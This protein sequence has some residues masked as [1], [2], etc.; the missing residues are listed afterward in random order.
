MFATAE[1]TSSTITSIQRKTEGARF[2]RK[3]ADE[4]FFGTKEGA[5]FFNAT[6]Q[7]KLS[8]SSPED[9]QEKEADA[10]AEQVMA[11]PE[12]AG[13]MLTEKKEEEKLQAREE[14]TASFGGGAVINDIQYKADVG[15][16][17]HQNLFHK[18]HRSQGETGDEGLETAACEC[19]GQTVNRKHILVQTSD[20]IQRT[21]R[22]PP[23][24]SVSFAQ[25]LA[26]SRGGGSALPDNTKQFMESRFNADFSGVRIHTGSTA[27]NLSSG[28]QAQAFTHGNDIYFNSN[29]YS[30]Q[31]SSGSLLL[32]HELTHTIQQGASTTNAHPQPNHSTAGSV[33]PKT[34][35]N[36][37]SFSLN[38][39]PDSNFSASR[40]KEH[41]EATPPVP[42]N[43]IQPKAEMSSWSID[44]G[45]KLSGQ[46]AVSNAFPTAT[47][48]RAANNSEDHIQA[49]EE[50]KKEEEPVVSLM[51]LAV[52]KKAAYPLHRAIEYN[53]CSA[54]TA[55]SNQSS[56]AGFA[57]VDN[58]LNAVDRSA[59]NNLSVVHDRGPPRIASTD[60][61]IHRSVLDDALSSVS[62]T[63]VLGCVDLLDLDA[64][65]ACVLDK[66]QEV[67]LHIPGF[68][69]LRVVLGYDPI[70]GDDIDRSG[71]NFIEAAFDIM[72][73][74]MLLHQKL[75]EQQQLDAAAAWIDV[76]MVKV[77]ELV[78]GLFGQINS[79]WDSLG[80]TDL[81]SPMDVL[82]DGTNI[83]LGFIGDIVDFAVE[84][85]TQL[86]EMVK[87]YLLEKIVDFI[88]EHTT[89][90]PLLCLVLGRDP[91]RDVEVDRN[92]TNILNALL[93]LGG[94]QGLMQKEQMQK[95]GT[96]QKVVDY[97]DQGIVVF[98]GAYEQILAGF[99]N[100]WDYVSIESLMDPGETFR[101]IFNQFAEPVLRVFLFVADVAAAILDYIKEV[102]MQRL[103]DWA[104][105]VRGYHVLTL[106]IGED[107]FTHEAVPFNVENVIHAF[108][109]LM[110][111]GEEQFQQM[112]QTGAIKRAATQV[113]AAV[114][115]LEMTPLAIIQLYIDLW[116]SFTLSD[117]VD[118]VSAYMRIL[119]TFAAPIF[120][121]IAFIAEIVRIVIYV[122][123]QI[124][125]FPFD[126]IDNIITR[127]MKAFAQ[128][129]ADP[130][131]FLK[132]ILKAIK[133]GFVQ[134]FEN[135]AT[136][137]LNGVT[138]WLLSELKDANVTAP[139]DFTL[140]GIISWVLELLGISMEKIWEKLAAHPRVGP[141]RVAQIKKSIAKLEG[142]WTFIRDVQ[143][144]GMAAIW[145]KIQEQLS[146]LWTVVLEAIT[147]WVMEKIIIQVTLYLLGLLDPTFIMS[148]V[149]S[150][151]IIYR[152]IRSFIRYAAQM[153]NV[154]NSFV[155]GI[156]DIAAGNIATAANYLEDSMGKAMPVVIGFL[157]DQAG[158]GGAGRKV[159]EMIESVREMVDKALTWLVNK[160]VD[161]GLALLDKAVALGQAA[162]G[163]VLDW[164]KKTKPV[165][166]K[167]GK[168]HTIYLEGSG[169][170][171]QLMM[172]STPGSYRNF[173]E[174]T[175]NKNGITAPL[176]G[177]PEEKA[178][179]KADE[180]D[181]RLKGYGKIEQEYRAIWG[182]Q[183]AVMIDDLALLTMQL[184]I[185]W[186][187]P[188][189]PSVIRFGAPNSE[190]FATVM[191]AELLSESYVAGEP[192]EKETKAVVGWDYARSFQR[193]AKS[194]K[195]APM[196][197]KGHL[198]N[199]NLGGPANVTNLTP[200]TD[201]MN[202]DHLNMVERDVKKLILGKSS[203]TDKNPTPKKVANYTV[204]VEYAK[205]PARTSLV[206]E[207]FRKMIDARINHGAEKRK[208]N[209]DPAKLAAF[210]A[211]DEAAMNIAALITYEDN[212]LTTGFRCQ[213][214]QL[215][216]S[217]ATGKWEPVA[218]TLKHEFVPHVLGDKIEH[219]KPVFDTF[220][221]DLQ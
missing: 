46:P 51:P 5:G 95:T 84:A 35:G 155:N 192:A 148:V 201:D 87:D 188:D 208:S 63:A 165:T 199:D 218:N 115:K 70:T 77:E 116:T 89:V 131:G 54:D 212:S 177:S 149:N 61:S 205:H 178:L 3:A 154:L 194:N 179:A 40:E 39:K 99:R 203:E 80:I 180:I 166:T 107:P 213:W 30:P 167:D 200:I 2:F 163:A 42:E 152:A 47:G 112:K 41:E 184:N 23:A 132:N 157:A 111:G 55:G 215:Q 65:K 186:D 160:A 143:D 76:Q 49:K 79:F 145:D 103:A 216:Y 176:P 182:E 91:I 204:D 124:M 126:V 102:L 44:S 161:T 210:A 162:V 198:L 73:G 7:P 136:H 106:I 156:A 86:L 15:Q 123:L 71:R 92:G 113:E 34:A 122:I 214:E 170:T 147:K 125:N 69:A 21:G 133:Q 67:A 171:Y 75:E 172:K 117:L 25:T 191:S 52:H 105:T 85:A 129:K 114:A 121:L 66:A 118:P 62:A 104:G 146:S 29:K 33:S 53:N 151:I 14:E 189:P 1:K 150:V 98:S 185:N 130:I 128:I 19:G 207:Y 11:M 56:H 32:A 82:R 27:E 158:L 217:V 173:I 140:Q 153:L 144:R 119:D 12:P 13:G 174:T 164:W 45:G 24:T 135:I 219:Y 38:S 59:A 93:E 6:I 26:S 168:N 50:E 138:G 9:P 74:G 22:G 18:I 202:K 8:V 142:I 187:V 58:T 4:S 120:R 169:E 206:N 110:E 221:T 181:T 60:E 109:S 108:M 139:T 83:I 31:T 17:R 81:G 20:A 78:D 190:G 37:H 68:R 197:V 175:L 90:Y 10:V 28:I 88:K 127:S 16:G 97:I 72:P 134:F 211:E 48:N 193:I 159:G 43:V 100:I 209:P 64:T 220:K 141:E 94:E 36:D 101:Q 57:C 196:Y 96:F 183:V 137:L 195:P